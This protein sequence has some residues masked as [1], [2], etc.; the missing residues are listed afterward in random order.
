MAQDFV[1]SNNLNLLIPSGQFGT[2]LAGGEDAA[3]PRYIFTHLSPISRYLFPEDDDILL[4]YLEE[5]G[6]KI[7]PKFFCPIIPLLLVN[8]S[9]G[10]GTGWS[11]FIPQHEPT[12]ILDY[13]RAK[14]DQTLNLPRI[15]PYTKGFQG[16]IERKGTGYTTYGTIKILDNITVYI[17][18][19]PIGVWTNK[20]K[21]FLLKKQ[22]KGEIVD[23]QE[24]HTTTKVSFTVKLKPGQ[25]H[26]MEQSGLEQ[27]F[28]LTS[29]LQLTNMNAFNAYGMIEKF[30]SAE[31]IADAYFPTRLSLYDD[32]KSVLMSEMNYKSAVLK[33]KAR[34]IQLVSEGKIDLIGGQMSEEKTVS[35]LKSFGCNTVDELKAFRNNTIIHE[36]LIEDDFS[37]SE[38][39]VKEENQNDKSSFDYLFKMPLSSLTS[40]KISALMK[41]A[42]ETESNL[43]KIRDLRSEE[44]WLS[45]LDK[46]APYL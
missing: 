19:L 36:K 43:N 26:R 42:S 21:S 22:S 7:E 3:S 46:L 4:D 1:G 24:D 41:E 44:L 37:W 32:R 10:I 17:D 29:N 18:E 25:L 28:K 39:E 14:L 23:F 13:V 27:A 11:T 8:G 6:Q 9:Q 12:S 20:Y 40:N 16:R 15:E 30:D 2:R 45:D 34:F 5:D 31:S 33:N 35:Q 38:D